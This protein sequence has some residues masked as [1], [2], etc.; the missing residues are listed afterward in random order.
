MDL[1]GGVQSVVRVVRLARDGATVPATVSLPMSGV[2]KWLGEEL[3]CWGGI[4]LWECGRLVVIKWDRDSG[5]V[6]LSGI[7]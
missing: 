7:T 6:A 1:G 4:L 5:V 2:C 3:L